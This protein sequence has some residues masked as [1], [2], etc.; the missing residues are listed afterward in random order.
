MTQLVADAPLPHAPVSAQPLQAPAPS[1]ELLLSPLSPPPLPPLPSP[2]PL[3]A[4]R[5]LPAPAPAP[6]P[7][8]AAALPPRPSPPTIQLVTAT[9]QGVPSAESVLQPPSPG[10]PPLAVPLPSSPAIALPLP[11][12]SAAAPPVVDTRP[13]RP[14]GVG[15]SVTPAPVRGPA[16]PPPSLLPACWA[17]RALLGALE[18]GC[19]FCLHARHSLLRLHVRS[20]EFC[21]ATPPTQRSLQVVYSPVA[22]LPTL[23][24]EPT[25]V[26]PLSGD[27][28][29]ASA[30]LDQA[31]CQTLGAILAQI[32]QTQNWTQLLKACR[33]AATAC[34]AGLP[35]AKRSRA[36]SQPQ[37]HAP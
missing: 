1:Q 36:G 5:P 37:L 11:A 21:G 27:Q 6:E 15:P 24:A 2:P 7:E 17:A 22:G 14:P 18:R 12:T 19:Q 33:W 30:G 20:T 26:G 28:L 25:A 10:G 13:P 23:P 16:V 29:A 9:P 8:A 4:L 35:L 3:P 32:P 34:W 31:S